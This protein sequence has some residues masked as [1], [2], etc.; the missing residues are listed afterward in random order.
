[1]IGYQPR[2]S[3]VSCLIATFTLSISLLLLAEDLNPPR[4]IQGEVL[5]PALYLKDGRHGVALV[6]ETYAAVDGGQSL[7]ILEDGTGLLYVLL[8]EQPG[9]DPNELVYDSLN[10][11]VVVTGRVYERGG[12]RGIVVTTAEAITSAGSDE[13]T[14]APSATPAVESPAPSVTEP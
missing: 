12:L 11:T 8:A 14:E 6:D 10:Q 13:A 1:M 4:T 2:R 9:E 5:D 7:A 3:I